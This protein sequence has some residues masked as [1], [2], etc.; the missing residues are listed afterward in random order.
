MKTRINGVFGHVDT[1]TKLQEMQGNRRNVPI[2]G[3]KI[4]SRNRLSR[5]HVSYLTKTSK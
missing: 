4:N 5:R 3:I 1:G 2:K